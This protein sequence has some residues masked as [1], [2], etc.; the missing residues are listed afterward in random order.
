MLTATYSL[1]A[2]AAE[3]DAA[4]RILRRLQQYVKN[5]WH[6]IQKIDFAIL[7]TAFDKLAEF[8]EYCRKRKLEVY[9][10]P[11]LRKAT[12]EADALLEEL[13]A[14]SE[15]GRS[16]LRAAREQFV[17]AVEAGT[18]RL[19]EICLSMEL[20]CDRLHARLEREEEELFPMLRRLLSV[21]EWFGIAA[22]FLS[23]DAGADG[24]KR[25]PLPQFRLPSAPSMSNLSIN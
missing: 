3:Q 18:A 22:Q 13:D 1:V 2:I 7:D 24:R 11:A 20:Y 17:G 16:V 19:H 6:G 4:R 9:V 25:Y 15:A 10:I 8:D 14:L 12:R 23:E 5:I 21:E